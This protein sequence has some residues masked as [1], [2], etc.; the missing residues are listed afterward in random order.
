MVSLNASAEPTGKLDPAAWLTDEATVKIFDALTTGG[1][2]VRFVGGCVRDALARRPVSDIDIGTPDEP[3][4]VIALLR[5]SEI[6]SVPTGLEHGTVTAVIGKK[7]FEITTLRR[8][9]ETDGRRAVVAFT[10]DW[11]VDSSRRDF[12]INAMSANRHGDVYDYHEGIPDLAHGRIRFIGRA[13]DRIQEDYLRILRYFRFYALLGRP[14]YD[15]AAFAACRKHA[16]RLTEIAAERIRY[17]ILRTLGAN[18]PAEAF[19]MMRDAHVLEVVLPEASEVG[20]L[21]TAAWLESRGL[22]LPGLHPDPL[23]RLGAVLGPSTDGAGVARRLRLSNQESKRLQQML[24]LLPA[25]KLPS[26]PAAT[27]RMMHRMGGQAVADTVIVSW[28]RRLADIGK[29]PLE[30]TEARRKQLEIALSWDAPQLPIDGRDAKAAGIAR[31]PAVG[32]ALRAVED[33]WAS[34]DF[35]AERDAC[36]KRL[37]E[38]ADDIRKHGEAGA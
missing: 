18:D 34:G 6:K 32:V 13:E 30:E 24:K 8:D 36:L 21:R 38:V 31:G 35:K 3:E 33:W 29:L 2:D 1:A 9:M 28:A 26:D 7:T 22:V 25:M 27:R 16:A 14:P 12:T 4:R 20:S 19:I 15:E 11:I 5:A 37:A 17:E 10:D 23:R